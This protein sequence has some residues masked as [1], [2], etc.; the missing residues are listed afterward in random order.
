MSSDRTDLVEQLC[1]LQL[2]RPELQLCQR[3]VL[4]NW[5][6]SIQNI[7]PNQVFQGLPK[8]ERLQSLLQASPLKSQLAA[9][10]NADLH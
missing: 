7:F 2:L 6:G 10:L 1:V 8:A 5:E 4:P 3:A 9:V